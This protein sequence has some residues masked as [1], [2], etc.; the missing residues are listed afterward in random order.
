VTLQAL[1][2]KL[3]QG[4]G[5]GAMGHRAAIGNLVNVTVG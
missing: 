1:L 2:S 5:Y 3:Q 4:L